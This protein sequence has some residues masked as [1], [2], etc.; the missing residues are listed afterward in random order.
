MKNIPFSNID[1]T[2]GFWKTKQDMVKNTTVK[3]VYDRFCDTHRFE[4]L[5]CS[6]KIADGE[7]KKPHIFWDSDVAKWIE[8][9]AYLISKERNDTL[10]AI[11]DSA[12]DSIVSCSDKNG[13]FNS[14]FLTVRPSEKLTHRGQHELYCLGHLIEGAI[15]YKNATGKD[16]FL[17]AM[18]KYTDYVDKVFRIEKK[19]GFVTPGHPELEL[20]LV[21]LYEETGEK[22]YLDLAYFFIDKHGTCGE[23]LDK[24]QLFFATKYNMDEMPLRDRTTIDGHSVRALYLLTGAADV[25]RHTGDTAL[26]E[27]CKRLFDNCTKK[28]MYITGGVGST[29]LGEA[30]TVDYHLPP[31]RAYTETCASIALVFFAS[32]MQLLE[33]NS[34][35]ADI[36][37]KVI[38][39]GVLSG[40]SLDGKSFFYEN[41]LELDPDFNDVNHSTSEK[42]RFPSTQRQEVFFCSCCP[43]NMVRFIPSIA[44]YIYTLDGDTLYVNQFMESNGEFDGITVSQT[45]RYP[46]DGDVKINCSG[47]KNIAVRIPCWCKSFEVNKPY[48]VENGYAIIENTDGEINVSFSMPVTLMRANIRVH[49]VAGRVAVTRGPVVYCLEGVD[50]GK[51][52]RNIRIDSQ[53]TFTASECDF[54]LPSITADGYRDKASDDLYF[55]ADTELEKTPLKFIPYFA[56]ANRGVSEMQVWVLEK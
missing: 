15:A 45:T 20:A 27:M 46:I 18:C 29:Y 55:N 35:Y 17:K 10:E 54:L 38:Y 26:T 21:K 40:I 28:R 22:R 36:I 23:V 34:K 53:G 1:I 13:Y 37:E 44:N 5:N 49:D 48:T 47:C 30:F 50:N 25:A 51:D 7:E 52:L 12:V 33:H 4:A 39:N 19:A 11:I 43:P 6:W 8:G 2:G 9:A 42:E 32:R 24:K 31:R 41:P 3:A 14:H 16:K 56:F